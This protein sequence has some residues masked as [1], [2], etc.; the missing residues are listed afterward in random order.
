MSVWAIANQKG[1]VGKTT[2]TLLLGR[3][4]A[5]RGQRVLLV[6]LDPHASLTRA[7]GIPAEPPPAGTLEL[8]DQ[9][10]G[11]VADLARNTPIT[12]LQLLPAQAGMATLE[13]RSATAPGL[14]LALGQGLAAAAADYDAVLLDCPPTLG[15]LMVNALAA[16]DQLLI[17]T[18]T[19]PLALHGMESMLRTA[20][21]IERSRRRPL[22]VRILPTLFDRRTRV[23]VDTL[24]VL[25][26]RHPECTWVQAVPLDTRL[27]DAALL[28]AP[29]LPNETLQGRGVDAYRRA[30]A[31]LLRESP[32]SA[33]M[34]PAG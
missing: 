14:G 24:A 29:E 33:A 13:R 25:H 16:A 21:M 32:Q 22:P 17:P 19:E 5:G 30:L 1:G 8:F 20:Q 18:Q 26:E 2:T 34:E 23:C 10:P 3:L 9:P 27:R 4:L 28:T 15:L 12:G 6:D 31:W 11:R 7:F